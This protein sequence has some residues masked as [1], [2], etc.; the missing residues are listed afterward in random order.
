MFNYSLSIASWSVLTGALSKGLGL[1]LSL[2]PRSNPGHFEH[3]RRQLLL[4]RTEGGAVAPHRDCIITWTGRSLY[5]WLSSN[6]LRRKWISWSA[7]SPAFTISA[8]VSFWFRC[9][10]ARKP[11]C[12]QTFPFVGSPPKLHPL[13]AATPHSGKEGLKSISLR[14][15][16]LALRKTSFFFFFFSPLP[17]LS[18]FHLKYRVTGGGTGGGT[19]YWKWFG[20]MKD[21]RRMV[22]MRPKGGWL[23]VAVCI[24]VNKQQ[25]PGEW[26]CISSEQASCEFGLLSFFK[27][28]F[29]Q[30]SAIWARR[31]AARKRRDE[32]SLCIP[33]EEAIVRGEIET[34]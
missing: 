33:G 17:W 28:E 1:R 31:E 16:Q 30:F 13:P 8:E 7:T 15:A 23:W 12:P 14:P 22:V 24:Y 3:R 2:C 29:W 11:Q 25:S 20:G 21:E 27:T 19:R 4:S 26:I 10:E 9:G 6:R 32:G 34:V 5:T 18:Q